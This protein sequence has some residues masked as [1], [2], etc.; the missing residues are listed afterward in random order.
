MKKILLGGI[1]TLAFAGAAHAQIVI[2][3][4]LSCSQWYADHAASNHDVIIMSLENGYVLGFTD[5]QKEAQ[6]GH[7]LDPRNYD[8]F[9]TQIT[10]Y[11]RGHPNE[12]ALAGAGSVSAFTERH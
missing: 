2:N 4:D 3:G 5:A 10:E 6:S 11:C 1:A 7:I 8:W 9:L 12:T